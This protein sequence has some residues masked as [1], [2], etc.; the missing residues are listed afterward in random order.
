MQAVQA[1]LAG[2]E[3]HTR[4]PCMC[5]ALDPPPYLKRQLSLTSE[6]QKDLYQPL[7]IKAMG[8]ARAQLNACAGTSG[9]SC[10]QTSGEHQ[11]TLSG[12]RRGTRKVRVGQLFFFSSV[13]HTP[14]RLWL[15]V[16]LLGELQQ[17]GQAK[18]APKGRSAW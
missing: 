12:S 10:L 5:G 1:C 2:R 13:L 7:E 16:L 3:A 6:T 11:L 9:V 4:Q 8:K 14:Q 18:P 17:L 15:S